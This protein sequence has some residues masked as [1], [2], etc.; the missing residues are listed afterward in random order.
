M[1]IICRKQSCRFNED[2]RCN[3]KKIDVNR[4]VH[5]DTFEKD[6][7][8][9]QP[10]DTSSHIFDETPPKYASHRE[11]KVGCIA[12]K[13]NCLFN[14]HGICEANGI[15]INDIKNCPFCVT[16]LEE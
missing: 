7:N 3:A 6:P 11:T 13:A 10:A 15:T 1:D 14:D 12:C 8:K 2:F 4:K 5:C 9:N 16:Y